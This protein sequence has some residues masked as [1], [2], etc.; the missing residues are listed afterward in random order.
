MNTE[1]SRNTKRAA[2]EED[3]RSKRLK[4]EY[5]S[6]ETM[7]PEDHDM[8]IEVA[9]KRIRVNDESHEGRSEIAAEMVVSEISDEQWVN[10]K[11]SCLN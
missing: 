6:P 4:Q 11:N 9:P 8:D 10:I 3:T 1:R 2:E 7:P 5:T